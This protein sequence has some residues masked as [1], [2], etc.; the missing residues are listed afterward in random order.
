MKKLLLASIF[1]AVWTP[2]AFAGLSQ[3]YVGQTV[4]G[5]ANGTSCASAIPV[6]FFNGAINWGD[7]ALQIGPG[8]TVHLCGTISTPLTA[9]GSGVSGSPITILFEPNAKISMGTCN[10][11]CLNLNKRS[12]IVVDGGTNGIIE[13]TAN[14]T[15]LANKN[16]DRGIQAYTVSNIE[17]KRLTIQNIYKFVCCGSDGAGRGIDVWG[18][19]QTSIHNNFVHD[20]LKGIVFSLG[21]NVAPSSNNAIYSNRISNTSWNIAYV[22]ASEGIGAVADNGAVIHDNDLRV[23]S[24]FCT[25]VSNFYHNEA[26]HVFTQTGSDNTIAN[27]FVYNNYVHGEVCP[28]GGSTNYTAV[29]KFSADPAPAQ[30]TA[31]I[32]NNLIVVTGLHTSN[33]LILLGNGNGIYGV[34]NNTLDASGGDQSQMGIE[35]GN[36]ATMD[37]KNNLFLSVRIAE[38]LDTGSTTVKGNTNDFYHPAGSYFYRGAG[39]LTFAEWQSQTGNDAHSITSAP[40]LNVRYFPNTGSPVI[41]VGTNLTSLGIA[42]LNFDKAG[43]LRPL[44]SAWDLG[45]YSY[46]SAARSL[47]APSTAPS[48]LRV[49]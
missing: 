6:T 38:Y 29:L 10:T 33:A 22:S 8:T 45:A 28:A 16:D 5:S 49:E 36:P 42:A 9:Q 15:G 20:A 34:Y 26:L 23:Q 12:Y 48:G 32:F 3:L 43:V 25:G 35:I 47:T 1:L 19:T 7:G 18:A 11:V 30:I 27:L 13:D 41:G 21:N 24:L 17:I 46:S 37:A 44:S 2:S 14:G 31:T 40:N 39:F 4:T